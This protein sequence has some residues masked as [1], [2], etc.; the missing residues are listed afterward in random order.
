MS[1]KLFDYSSTI[2]FIVSTQ[3]Q[4]LTQQRKMSLSKNK[5]G[6]ILKGLNPVSP[7][8]HTIS[9]LYPTTTQS[10]R[11]KK[12]RNGRKDKKVTVQNQPRTQTSPQWVGVLCVS[13]TPFSVRVKTSCFQY[14][15]RAELPEKL[16]GSACPD[17][18]LALA[19][20]RSQTT[21]KY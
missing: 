17:L 9:V 8:N 16:N 13:S 15:E 3:T 4:T 11:Q 21:E 12:R 19:G 18:Q 7:D 14:L 1:F 10:F 5:M 20:F 2:P 6:Q